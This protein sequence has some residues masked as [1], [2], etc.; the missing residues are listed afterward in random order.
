[1]KLG[2]LLRKKLYTPLYKKAYSRSA[3]T[4]AGLVAVEIRHAFNQFFTW[5]Y[6]IRSLIRT[7]AVIFSSICRLYL[8]RSVRFSYAFAGEDRLIEGLLNPKVGQRGFYV[9]VGANHPTLFSNTYSFYRRGWR[10]I[11]VD[12]NSEL[13]HL[14][15]LYRPR[16]RAVTALV[17]DAPGV[18]EFYQVQNDVLSTTMAENLENYRQEG[19]SIAV[20]RLQTRSL[21]EVLIQQEAPAIFDLLTV[22][23]E[24]HDLQVLKS[25]DLSLFRPRLIV[26]EDDAFDPLLPLENEIYSYLYQAGYRLEGFVL[27]NL[28]FMHQ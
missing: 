4:L 21:T 7:V 2:Y 28:Y 1:M 11:C 12:A 8:G 9:D 5:K 14:Y 27:K 3:L 10:G 18:R 16:D 20:A 15:R 17:S 19:L 13:I 22:D 24:E 23:T 26:V 6:P 25:L